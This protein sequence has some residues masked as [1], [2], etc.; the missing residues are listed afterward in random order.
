MK[1]YD[2]KIKISDLLQQP[3]RQDTLFLKNKF[4]TKIPQLSNKGITCELHIIWLDEKTLL[5]TIKNCTATLDYSCDYCWEEMEFQISLPKVEVK[6]F[7]WWSQDFE[8]D[9]IIV[10]GEKD[11]VIDIEN[12]L[13]ESLLL[14]DDVVHICWKCQKDKISDDEIDQWGIIHWKFSTDN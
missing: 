10:V 1:D 14:L 5:L 13:T 2:F 3:W 4:S 7:V 6:I 9:D 8:S 12:Y 11:G